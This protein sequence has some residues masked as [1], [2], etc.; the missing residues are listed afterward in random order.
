LANIEALKSWQIYDKKRY[1][2]QAKTFSLNHYCQK[3]ERLTKYNLL[4]IKNEW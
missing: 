2:R 3:T 1:L 4:Q